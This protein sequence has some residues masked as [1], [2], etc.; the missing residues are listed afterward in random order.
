MKNTLYQEGFDFEGFDGADVLLHVLGEGER[1]LKSALTPI[2]AGQSLIEINTVH[3]T[4]NV[5]S[6][7]T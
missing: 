2:S 7:V 1:A 4:A 6:P 5:A 3:P